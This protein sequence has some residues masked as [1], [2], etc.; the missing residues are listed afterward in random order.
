MPCA[1]CR[2]H[3]RGRAGYY[4]LPPYNHHD[5]HSVFHVRV[6]DVLRLSA[7]R[8]PLDVFVSHD[9]PRNIS[10]HGNEAQLLRVKPFL[11]AD[12]AS[13]EFGS[14]PGEHLLHTLR[15]R[16]WFSAH[17][18]CRFAALVRHPDG[19]ETR[20]L[21]LDKVLPG[22]DFL[23]VLDLP[24]SDDAAAAAP[25]GLAYDAEWLALLR[26]THPMVSLTRYAH[27]PDQLCVAF[28]SCASP[29]I[30]VPALEH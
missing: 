26:R 4:E 20:F 6:M 11:R 8:R 1:C 22:R 30:L 2:P 14:E 3:S 25:P 13:G 15:P 21:A 29:C 9:W 27:M 10:K 12:I 19:R 23:Q 24:V 5:L 18:H 16:Y 7:L 28:H 17:M